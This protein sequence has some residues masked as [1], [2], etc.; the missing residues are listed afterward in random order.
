MANMKLETLRFDG[1]LMALS[2]IHTGASTKNGINNMTNRLPFI[3]NGKE[4]KIPY[5]TGNGIRGIL[6]RMILDDFF[7]QVNYTPKTPRLH[8]LKS[9]GALETEISA[10]DAARIFVDLRRDIHNYIA[11]LS[12]FGFALGNQT[13]TGKFTVG[14]AVPFCRELNQLLPQSSTISYHDIVNDDIFTTRHAERDLSEEVQANMK[15]KDEEPTIQMKVNWECIIPGTVLYHY[16][17]LLDTNEVEKSCFARIIELFKQ[18][19]YVGGKKSIGWGEVRLDYPTIQY[20]TD[21]YFKFLREHRSEILAILEKY[22]KINIKAKAKKPKSL[23]G[24]V[25]ADPDEAEA[26]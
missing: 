9:G 18:R 14:C 22:D 24:Q 8:Y 17:C 13:L 16:F 21:G 5:V 25:V 11:P 10:S 3:I 26:V 1:S 19:P 6:R 4:E 15:D 20:S 23:L 2:L 12:L 7:E